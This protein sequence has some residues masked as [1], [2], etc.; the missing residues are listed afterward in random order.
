[1]SRDVGFAASAKRAAARNLPIMTAARAHA[2]RKSLSASIH[3]MNRAVF[4]RV[5]A[6][7]AL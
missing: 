7:G 1:M 6:K 5:D 3:R 4:G 2:G